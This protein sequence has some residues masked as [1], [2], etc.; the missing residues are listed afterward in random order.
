MLLLSF[1]GPVDLGHPNYFKR[2]AAE[3]NLKYLPWI[4]YQAHNEEARF[5]SDRIAERYQRWIEPAVFEMDPHLWFEQYGLWGDNNWVSHKQFILKVQSCNELRTKYDSTRLFQW[6]QPS[7]IPSDLGSYEW[8]RL[9]YQKSG[10]SPGLVVPQKME[11]TI[12]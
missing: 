9:E 11:N 6:P 8:W 5:R 1:F 12:R 3:Q 7:F 2:E 10:H 4:S